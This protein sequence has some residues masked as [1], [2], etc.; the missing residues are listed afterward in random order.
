MSCPGEGQTEAD[1]VPNAF[2]GGTLVRDIPPKVINHVRGLEQIV[3]LLTR[4]YR[5]SG[6]QITGPPEKV[7]NET[8]CFL[9]YVAGEGVGQSRICQG[10]YTR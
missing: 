8:C 1:R 2:V 5:R 7:T 10:F 9:A 6:E 4:V 3:E